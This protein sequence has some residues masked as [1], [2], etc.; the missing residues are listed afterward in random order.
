MLIFMKDLRKKILIL[1]F[2]MAILSGA[3]CAFAGAGSSGGGTAV[4]VPGSSGPVLLDLY[5]YD[6]KFKDVYTGTDYLGSACGNPMQAKYGFQDLPTVGVASLNA[7]G[8][9]LKRLRLFSETSPVMVQL[10]LYAVFS[11]E[12]DLTYGDVPQ[13]DTYW[14]PD[15]FEKKDIQFE[16]AA[17][18]QIDTGAVISAQVYNELGA[19][20]QQALLIHEALRELQ[21][22]FGDDISEEMLEMLTALIILGPEDGTIDPAHFSLD[23]SA[24]YG[25]KLGAIIQ[26]FNSS[27][28]ELFAQSWKRAFK[29]GLK[30]DDGTASSNPNLKALFQVF[31]TNNPCVR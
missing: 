30:F 3:P 14:L 31:K 1:V 20:S 6:P 15:H 17:F 25:P 2:G 10:I 28:E 4:H 19:T 9:A 18:Y 13:V 22:G 16:T 5:L 27:P 23:N 26:N 7:F 21:I 11:N 29:R 8:G 24:L 12:L